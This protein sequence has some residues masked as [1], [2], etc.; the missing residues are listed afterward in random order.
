MGAEKCHHI[1]R[2]ATDKTASLGRLKLAAISISGSFSLWISCF[3]K[4]FVENYFLLAA[5]FHIY[6]L[7]AFYFSLA[8]PGDPPAK[9]NNKKAPAFRRSFFVL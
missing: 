6:L 3:L 1:A 7:R 4:P 2:P 5:G 8:L 9:R